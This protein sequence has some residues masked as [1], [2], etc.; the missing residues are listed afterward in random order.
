MIQLLNT[1]TGDRHRWLALWERT[2]REP[3]AHPSYVA[4]FAQEG[5]QAQALT[6]RD[7]LGGDDVLLPFIRRP[8]PQE[9]WDICG[10]QHF[11][12]D[13]VSPYGYGGPFTTLNNQI[14]WNLFWADVLAWMRLENVLTFFVRASLE[15]SSLSGLPAETQLDCKSIHLNDN[16]VVDLRR[17]EESQW[18]HYEHKVRKNVKKAERA[19]LTVRIQSDFRNLPKFIDIYQS[20]MQRRSANGWYYFDGHFFESFD[21]HLRGNF[22][23]AEVYQPD[24]TLVSTELVLESE[25]FLYSYLGGTSKDAFIYAPNDLLKHSVIQYGRS[26]GKLGYVLGGGYERDDGIFKYKK[27]FDPT[28][29]VEFHGIQLIA[30]PI[31]YGKLTDFLLSQERARQPNVTLLS[32]FF[33]QYRAPFTAH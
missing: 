19:D 4:L 11:W 24:G 6:W 32:N 9:L 21:K 5:E 2:G 30:D 26:Q 8:L 31:V 23:V 17:P 3:F 1:T 15:I 27:S 20:T 12:T 13:A 28:G 14:D 29:A 18:T 7:P 25:R 22:I 10:G 16:I 33:P